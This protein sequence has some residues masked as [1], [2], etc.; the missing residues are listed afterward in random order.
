MTYDELKEVD[1]LDAVRMVLPDGTAVTDRTLNF[2]PYYSDIIVFGNEYCESN[3]GIA[4]FIDEYVCPENEK[5][6]TAFF[7]EIARRIVSDPILDDVDTRKNTH[8]NYRL[9]RDQHY[10]LF[11][12]P[13]ALSEWS[14][15]RGIYFWHEYIIQ[16]RRQ[17]QFKKIVKKQDDDELFKISYKVKKVYGFSEREITYLQ[18]FCSQ[19][20]LDDLDSSLNVSLYNW[21]KKKFTG[22]STVSEYI[23]S[24]LNGETTKNA[25]KYKSDLAT[26]MQMGRFDI[27]VATTSRCTM[28]D[29]AGFKDMS[30][31]YSK[32]KTVITSNTCNIEYKYK[33]SKRPKRCYRNYIW[34]SNDDPI[35]LIKDEDE[36]R[37]LA[38]HFAKPEK[39]SF[40]ELE[41][42]WYKFVLECNFDEKRLSEIYENV[43]EPNP[44]AGESKLII[45]ELKDILTKDRINGITSGSYFSISNVMTIPEIAQQKADINRKIVKEAVMQ[46]YGLP[47][48]SQRFYKINRLIIESEN[49]DEKQELPF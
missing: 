19:A 18:Y 44:Q 15:M 6:V 37:I 31:T 5:D 16:S 45:E 29:E 33:S 7:Q 20:K 36:R 12:K 1:R 17:E 11:K 23:C 35:Y 46:L 41:K 3:E 2:F 40:A 49:Y 30:K 22:K 24:F 4:K 48:A 13:D 21:S 42:L 39:M 14:E 27:P 38:V 8:V 28:L 43:I 25:D 34:T 32:L 9:L 47:D 10:S 26:E